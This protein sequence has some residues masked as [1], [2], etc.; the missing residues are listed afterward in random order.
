MT[1]KLDWATIEDT[2]DLG[3][4]SVNAAL[5]NSAAFLAILGLTLLQPEY[6]WQDYEDFDDVETAI[7][8]AIAQIM[9]GDLGVGDYEQIGEEIVIA[10]DTS[11]ICEIDSGG[12][13]T[14]F[15]VI[16][17]GLRSNRA[18]NV[19]DNCLITFN[20]NV[21]AAN[22][23]SVNFSFAGASHVTTQKIGGIVGFWLP[24]GI[25][26]V[27]ADNGCW[28]NIKM[29]IF[30]PLNDDRKTHVDWTCHVGGQTSA[31][32]RRTIGSGLFEVVDPIE[33]ISIEPEHGT[34]FLIDPADADEPNELTI[35]VYGRK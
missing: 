24:Y 13:W 2:I 5:T 30:N 23:N 19:V 6:L 7:D 8:D 20:E 10:D 9:N 14:S 32:I 28:S 35:R 33:S 15:D 16:M 18:A 17:S 3:G 29:T 31:E 34:T 12:D 11:V 21:V 22:Y 25:A 4:Y 1:G 27:L 26:A